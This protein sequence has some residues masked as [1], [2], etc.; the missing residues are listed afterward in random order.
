VTIVF[1]GDARDAVL[2]ALGDQGGKD[3]MEEIDQLRAHIRPQFAPFSTY[4][5]NDEHG[6][7]Q[8]YLQGCLCA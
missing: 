6:R 4:A 2:M 8:G 3:K 7:Q 1:Y 5:N